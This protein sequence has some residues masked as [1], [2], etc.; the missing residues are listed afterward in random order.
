MALRTALNETPS[1]HDTGRAL[2]GQGTRRGGRARRPK[3]NPLLFV[4]RRGLQSLLAFFDLAF[5]AGCTKAMLFIAGDRDQYCS[6][7]ELTRQLAGIAQS[8]TRCLLTGADHFL[9]GEESAVTAAVA[10]FVA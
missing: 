4:R 1:P 3:E 7:A 10:D 5:L 2:D 9:S 6:I 8:T